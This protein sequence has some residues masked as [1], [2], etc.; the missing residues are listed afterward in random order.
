[1]AGR[2]A[3]P[4]TGFWLLSSADFFHIPLLAPRS[5][6]AARARIGRLVVLRKR[7]LCYVLRS[8]RNG[9]PEDGG[10][11]IIAREMVRRKARTPENQAR[12]PIRFRTK[13]TLKG[14]KVRYLSVPKC[15]SGARGLIFFR[16]KLHMR[17]RPPIAF[18]TKLSCR[19]ADPRAAAD[20]H[21]VLTTSVFEYR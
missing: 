6:W 18:R 14:P 15:P 4:R 10:G 8:A 3:G 13:M 1:M 2:G 19:P 5:P 17:P 12:G 9:A 16:T 7:E 21:L 20:P 11:V